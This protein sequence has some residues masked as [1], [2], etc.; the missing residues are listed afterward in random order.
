MV[1]ATRHAA[2]RSAGLGARSRTV[3]PCLR[4]DRGVRTSGGITWTI[5]EGNRFETFCYSDPKHRAWVKKVIEHT[6]RLF[7][8]IIL[9]DFFFTSCKSDIEIAAK[10]D[11]ED[12]RKAE[13]ANARMIQAIPL[14]KVPNRLVMSGG[15]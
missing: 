12:R 5:D 8:E 9:D 1:V 4:A 2:A 10:G 11:F 14:D 3:W 7:D 6:A 13:E 15:Y